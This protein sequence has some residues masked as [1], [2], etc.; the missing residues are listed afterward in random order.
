M[1]RTKSIGDNKEAGSAT[2]AA[3]D[4]R[5]Q[6][7]TAEMVASEVSGRVFR[8]ASVTPLLRLD[9]LEEETASSRE[10]VA[11]W[12]ALY[13][14]LQ[15]LMHVVNGQHSWFLRPAGRHVTSSALFRY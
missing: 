1:S 4:L 7:E 12:L 14:S 13:D 15:M 10:C 9:W 6:E 8:I 5:R 2:M 11:P 3:A